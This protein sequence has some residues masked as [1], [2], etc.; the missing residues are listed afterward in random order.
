MGLP[1]WYGVIPFWNTWNQFQKTWATMPWFFVWLVL[2]IASF[3]GVD[4]IFGTV[5]YILTLAV[6]IAANYQLAKAFGKGVGYCVGLTL[7]PVVFLPILALGSAQYQGNPTA[8][9]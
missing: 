7:V 3:V 6:G 4:G 9:N 8:E 2:S 5:V 1:G